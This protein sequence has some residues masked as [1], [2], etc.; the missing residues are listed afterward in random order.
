MITQP[1]YVS[2]VRVEPFDGPL[3]RIHLPAEPEPLII[4]S[5]GALAAHYGYPT[6]APYART[7]ALDLLVA[8]VTG[9]LS[10]TLAGA[11]RA[12]G[13]D[14]EAGTLVTESAADIAPEDDGVLVVRRIEVHH[15]LCLA[16]EDQRAPAERAH[17]VH[18]RACAVH[19]SVAAAVPVVTTLEIEVR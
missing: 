17:A 7:S 1:T 14:V 12:R 16:S 13:I 19:R 18:A 6:E 11:L 10:G 3:R 8:A 9:C 15:R 2:R 5:H 4:G